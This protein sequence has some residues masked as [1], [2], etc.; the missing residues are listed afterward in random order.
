MARHV[1]LLGGLAV[2]GRAEH[3]GSQ[4]TAPR[5]PDIRYV[6]AS[7]SLLWGAVLTTILG[8]VHVLAFVI[9]VI[10]LGVMAPK[11]TASFVFVEFTNN[12]GWTSDGA[13][14]LVGLLS[15]VPF[16]RVGL[17]YQNHPVE[18]LKY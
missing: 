13:S 3:L 5:E 10:I 15:R 8:V 4:A 11:N 9:I 12:S 7:K 18:E 6:Y 16:P 2:R 17:P 14:W 1:V